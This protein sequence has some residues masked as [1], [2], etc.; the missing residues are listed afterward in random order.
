LY[1]KSFGL[2]SF[3][4]GLTVGIRPLIQFIGA[5]LWAELGE[6]HQTKKLILLGGLLAWIIKGVL[7]WSVN[8]KYQLCIKTSTNAVTNVSS[9]YSRNLWGIKDNDS[10]IIWKS[11]GETKQKISG[12]NII[13]LL[14]HASPRVQPVKEFNRSTMVLVPNNEENVGLIINRYKITSTVKTLGTG[15]CM[16]TFIDKDEVWYLFLLFLMIIIIGEFFESPTYA[17]SDAS[18]LNRL[19][20]DRDYYGQIRLWGAVGWAMSTACSGAV[21]YSTRSLMCAV[22]RFDYNVVYYVYFGFV[23]CAVFCVYWFSFKKSEEEQKPSMRKA[24]KILCK[25]LHVIF[26]L[27]ILFSGC[28]FGFLF[29]F[30]NWYIDD[31][32]GSTLVMGAAGAARELGEMTFFFL[33]GTCVRFLGHMNSMAICLLCYAACFYWFSII[34]VPWMAVPLEALDG[35]IYGL[36]WCTSISYMS[37]LGAPIGAVVIMQGNYRINS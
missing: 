24:F 5:P 17:L 16:F 35:S 8:P 31:K 2:S 6:R 15:E 10:S 36:V 18:L 21:L 20:D 9:I 37:S 28:C 11:I 1:F 13:D 32:G 27:A 22:L 25:P 30:V 33:G 34:T 26:L 19:G 29:H 12:K 4:S 14:E 23:S 7:L 3:Q